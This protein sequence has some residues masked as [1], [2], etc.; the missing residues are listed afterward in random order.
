MYTSIVCP[1]NFV[2]VKASL[3]IRKSW[4][5]DHITDPIRKRS[6]VYLANLGVFIVYEECAVGNI[7]AGSLTFRQCLYVF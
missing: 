2:V 3:K 7:P 4:P 6:R 1:H 5:V